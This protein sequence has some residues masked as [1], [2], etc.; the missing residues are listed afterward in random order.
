MNQEE[1][2]ERMKDNRYKELVVTKD[3]K[4]NKDYVF[5]SYR[6]NSWRKV[7]TNIVY[8]LQKKYKLRIYFDKEF[9]SETNVWVDQFVNNMESSNCKAFLCFF[10]EGYVTSYATLIELMHA[11]TPRS[12]LSD[13]IYSINFKIDWDKLKDDDEDTGLGKEDQ[14]NPG[15]KDEKERFKIDFELL[16]EKYPKIKGYYNTDIEGQ[17]LRKNDCADI[18]R[19]IQPKNQRIFIDDDDFYKQFIITPLKKK[20]PTVFEDYIPDN[21]TKDSQ[22]NPLSN[23]LSAPTTPTGQSIWE[24]KVKDANAQLLWDGKT[25]GSSGITVL[26]GSQTATPAEKFEKNCHASFILK[27][28]LEKQ[29]ILKN[30]IFTKDYTNDTV[31]VVINLLCG[32]S[33]SVPAE[34]KNGHIHPGNNGLDQPKNHSSDAATNTTEKTKSEET[35]DIQTNEIPNKSN[36]SQNGVIEFKLWGQKQTVKNQSDMMHAVFDLIAEKYP[37][38][39]PEM[40]NSDFVSS[41]AFK[42]DYDNGILHS[43][44]RNYFKVRKEH[45]VGNTA[46]YVG[47]SYSFGGKIKQLERMLKFCE[48][49][50]DGFELINFPEIKTKTY[51]NSNK[52]GLSELL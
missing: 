3:N 32:G 27:K 51:G 44:K 38:K 11:M 6:G 36:E 13:A 10:D 35:P 52:K 18:F 24:Y 1:Y 30:G 16:A 34:K 22:S 50:S 20:C 42:D 49:N 19:I 45:N 29:G 21:T 2:V 31:Q 39:I 8:K 37:E 41:V 25:K 17:K 33:V 12:R 46:Y 7:L 15:W 28:E 14:N 23:R 47:T 48:G 9:A 26:A 43:S 40:A 5:I 4:E